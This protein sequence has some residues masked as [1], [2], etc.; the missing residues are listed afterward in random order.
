MKASITFDK[1]AI[2]KLQYDIGH[3]LRTEGVYESVDLPQ[4]FR[5]VTISN[6]R[7]EYTTLFVENDRVETLFQEDRYMMWENVYFTE[8]G[9]KLG[10]IFS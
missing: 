8:T 5:L 10:L 4:G 7:K 9:E 6:P 3:V 2:K 1:P